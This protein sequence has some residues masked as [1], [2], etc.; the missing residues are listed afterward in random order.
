MNRYLAASALTLALLATSGSSIAATAT[1]QR[2]WQFA[3]GQPAGLEL[4]NFIGDLRIERGA[5]AGF[6]VSVT[7]T[8]EAASDA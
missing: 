8:G 7:V 1:T 4:D 6:Q 5:G 3:D 2:D